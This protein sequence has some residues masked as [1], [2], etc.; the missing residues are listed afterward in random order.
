[1]YARSSVDVRRVAL[2]MDQ[3]EAFQPPPNPAKESDKRFEA[4]RRKYGDQ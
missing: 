1:L 2:N 3:V 4:Y